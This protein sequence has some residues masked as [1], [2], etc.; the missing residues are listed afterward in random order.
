MAQQPSGERR[1]QAMAQ[2]REALLHAQQALV[3]LPPELRTK[4]EYRDAEA[5]LGETQQ[6]LQGDQAN[7]Q[8][9]QATVD[10]YVVLI[11]KIVPTAGATGVPVERVSNLIGT[12]LIGPGDKKVAEIEN[13]WWIATVRSGPWWRSGAGSLALATKR[14]LCPLTGFSLLP[15]RATAREPA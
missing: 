4:Q 10:A 15:Q 13:F 7:P 5:R 11:P 2:A 12:D 9:A 6:A 14:S 1:N 8:R 3:Q